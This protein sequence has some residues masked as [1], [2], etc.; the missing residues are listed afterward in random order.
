MN[1][2]HKVPEMP[3]WVLERIESL[4]FP[5]FARIIKLDGV[6]FVEIPR[7]AK[8]F[9]IICVYDDIGNE[10]HT[11]SKEMNYETDSLIVKLS[12]KTTGFLL[13]NSRISR[14]GE[15]I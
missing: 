10:V 1:K 4:M 2:K 11:V 8:L 7:E 13:Y 14:K 6:D 9:S 15:I 12:K 5:E 3:E